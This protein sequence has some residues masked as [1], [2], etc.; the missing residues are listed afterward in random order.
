MQEQ[1]EDE[2]IL[3]CAKES[4]DAIQEAEVRLAWNKGMN[5]PYQ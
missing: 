3:F 1:L 2:T 5:S 4:V